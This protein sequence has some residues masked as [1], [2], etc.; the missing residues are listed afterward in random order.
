MVFIIVYLCTQENGLQQDEIGLLESFVCKFE[1]D[2]KVSSAFGGIIEKVNYFSKEDIDNLISTA[3]S[4]FTNH[5]YKFK[6][7]HWSF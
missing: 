6:V 4:G 1:R 5:S 7:A 2:I 3:V